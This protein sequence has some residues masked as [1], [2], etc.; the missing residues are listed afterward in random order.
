MNVLSIVAALLALQTP[1]VTPSG[2]AVAPP[3]S[4]RVVQGSGSPSFGIPRLSETATI[5]GQL[6]EPAW[7]QAAR[8]TGF[9]EYRPVDG[10]PASEQTDVLVWYSPTAL[11]FGIIAHDS[12]PGSIR[13]TNADRDNIDRDDSVRIFLDTFNDRRRAFIFGVNPLGVQED[14][15]QTE[16]SFN[17]GRMFGQ[18]GSVDLS[19]DYQFDS[20]GRLTPDGYV[21]EIR[22]PFKSLRYPPAEGAAWGLNVL[23]KTQ[24]TGREDTWTD[25][26][27]VASFLAQSGQMTGFGELQRGVVTEVQ[28]FVTASSTGTRVSASEFSRPSPEF[29]AGANLRLGFTNASVDAT[30]NPDFSQVESDAAQVTVNERFALFF[31]EKRPFF[32]EGIE[33]F[34]TPNQL[35]YTRRIVDPIGGGKLTG[36]TGKTGFAVLAALDQS[37][38][39]DTWSTI[40]RVR[41]DVGEN[42]LA[43]VTYTDRTNADGY[44]RVAAADARIVFGKLYYVLGQVGGAWTDAGGGARTSA[45]MFQVEFDRTAR[46][47]GFNY[48]LT[49]FGRGFDAQSGYVPRS[50]MVEFRAFN[51]FTYYGERGSLLETASVF[52]GPSRLW[53]YADFGRSAPLEGGESMNL[54]ATLRGG[55]SLS[56]NVARA[57]VNFDPAAFASYTVATGNGRVAFVL[58]G[59]VS[60]WGGT[61]SVTTPVFEKLNAKLEF[62]RG[63]TALF[64]EAGDGVETRVTA[65]LGLRPTAA[66]RIEGSIVRSQILRDRDD[67][68]FAR[69]TIPRVKLEFQPKR[70][71]FFR[72]ITEYRSDRRAALVDP[73]TG[74]AL[75]VG[76]APASEQAFRGLRVDWLVSFK[77]TPGTVAFFGY[78]SSL[79][80]NRALYN[81]DALERT[82]DGFFVK[83]AYLIRK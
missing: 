14:G 40:A 70:S 56:A 26:R 43:G 66:I 25:A 62:K 41:Q 16:G 64:A 38:T 50:N 5:D 82:S 12:Q 28:P 52:F 42:S 77:P 60:N 4:P 15:V 13:A 9:S 30:F 1:S 80:R 48:R 49:G 57:F 58:P 22:I 11:H 20:K 81:T 39:R 78:G 51:R 69:S 2:P 19:P 31:A 3:S 73:F 61:Y 36:K 6:N 65:T 33:L 83:L 54:S 35:V 23:R 44:N 63:G 21:V 32:L 59:E 72:L 37:G 53:K 10:Q 7:Q 34:S 29:S 76:A 8:L 17:A 68:E 71:L 46:T 18:N 79:E 45:P 74:R 27:R 75:Y 55:W 67:S 24:R 47:W